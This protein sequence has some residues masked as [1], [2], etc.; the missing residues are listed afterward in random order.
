MPNVY[1]QNNTV[2]PASLQT[3]KSWEDLSPSDAQAYLTYIQA[4]AERKTA[5]ARDAL[6]SINN[7]SNK[8]VTAIDF[9]T[10]CDTIV[11]CEK[12]YTEGTGGQGIA[13]FLNSFVYA[14]V[15]QGGNTYNQF[16]IVT[17]YTSSTG[18]N[19]YLCIVPKAV[20]KNPIES[21]DS[22][23]KISTSSIVNAKTTWRGLYNSSNN[24][25]IGDLVSYNN[26]W[27]LAKVD[28]PTAP[29]LIEEQWEMMVDFNVYQNVVVS[30]YEPTGQSDGDLW[31]KV[32]G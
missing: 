2:F 21:T 19:L 15:W 11:A 25:Y 9:N 13:Q 1:G 26:V 6:L 20:N 30:P 14:G 12:F 23:V 24:Y 10:I 7:Y 3:F 31:F 29:L 17:Y 32:V 27:Y 8:V 5:Q 22:W 18:S 28:N 4:L 16:N